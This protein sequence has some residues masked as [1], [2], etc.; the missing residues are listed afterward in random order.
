MGAP[1]KTI[2]A[3]GWGRTLTEFTLEAGRRDDAQRLAPDVHTGYLAT[4]GTQIV[5]RA[6]G[7][8]VRLV[9]ANWFGAEGK[10]LIPNGLWAR[11]YMDMMDEM[12]EAGINLLR[13]PISP[14]ILSDQ[15][16]TAGLRKDISPSLV[17]LTAIEIM[18]EIIEYAGEIGI[19][20]VLD[21]HRR[22]AGVGKQK[23]GLWFSDDYSIED[24]AA[25]WQAIAGRYAGDPTVIGAD[26]FNEP[27]GRARWGDEAPSPELDWAAAAE[28]LGNAILEANPDLLILV[29]GVHVVD[30]RWYWVGGNLKGARER[31]IELD[32]EGR[33]VYSPHD[34]PRSVVD[35]PWLQATP[36]P[37]RW[38]R[39]SASIGA[40]SW[41]RGSRPC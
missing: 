35:V 2:C 13:L 1:R 19:R 6:T 10:T 38:W 20:V 22:D 39:S 7:E 40:T 33:L 29:Q 18:D 27:S 5:D 16:V 36:R 14:A 21:M 24:M 26:V 8:P 12:A 32:L 31:P 28:T 4:K 9:G 25:D 37:R 23:D 3:I 34:Y 15:I 41:R 30:E 17:G 11:N